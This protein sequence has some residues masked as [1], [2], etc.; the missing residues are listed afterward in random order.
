MFVEVPPKPRHYADPHLDEAI[1]HDDGTRPMVAWIE[2][3][4]TCYV[5]PIGGSSG[6]VELQ[7]SAN[8]LPIGREWDVWH[9]ALA[10]RERIASG[11]TI[12][13]AMR[14]A[15]KYVRAAAGDV[16]VT[17]RERGW[18]DDPASD[19]QI[20]RLMLLTGA[21]ALPAMTAGE[22]SDQLATLVAQ[23]LL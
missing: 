23:N 9:V 8:D 20:G 12:N 16:G 22:V 19:K 13:R 14:F 1:A 2:K 18:R 11:L 7:G 5:C 4:G 3:D 15:E 6:Q 21:L 17:V 10:G